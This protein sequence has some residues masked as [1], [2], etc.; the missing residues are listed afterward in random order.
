MLIERT[1]REIIIRLPA[2]VDTEDLQAMV[3]YLRYRE[4]VSKVKVP[5]KRVDALARQVNRAWWQKNR[6]RFEQ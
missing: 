5:Q 3:N 6:K 1:K 2:S 4:I